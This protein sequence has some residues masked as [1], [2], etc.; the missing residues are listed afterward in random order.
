MYILNST[1]IMQPYYFPYIGYFKLIHKADIW[2]AF[3]IVQYNNKSWMNRNRILH[4]SNG[5]QYI[6]VPVNKAE[7]GS[8]IN[9]ITVVDKQETLRKLLAQI[10][11]YKKYALFFDDVVKVIQE[12]FFKTSSDL[13]LDLNLSTISSVCRYL[14]ISFNW[15]LCSELRIDNAKIQHAGDWALEISDEI[16]AKEYFN[17]PGGVPL[18][19]PEDWKQRNIG[20]NFIETDFMEYNCTPYVFEK[21]LS[22]ID[23]LMWNDPNSLQDYFDSK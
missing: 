2:L 22:I 14:G 11:H 1:A 10:N 15:K 19:N 20:L 23:V 13:L 5:W 7:H 18:F 8:S 4:P 21:N 17:L 16:G 6:N 9:T 12:G 3:D